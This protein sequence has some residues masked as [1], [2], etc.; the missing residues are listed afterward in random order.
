MCKHSEL[1][2]RTHAQSG[3][4]LSPQQ[5][6]AAQRSPER[7]M[8]RTAGAAR[9]RLAAPPLPPPGPKAEQASIR[10]T[11]GPPLR[12]A[13]RRHSPAKAPGSARPQ[14]PPVLTSPRRA[15]ARHKAAQG[16]GRPAARHSQPRGPPAAGGDKEGPGPGGW[17]GGRLRGGV[18][19]G[20][21]AGPALLPERA[22]CISYA[23]VR[24]HR[25]R[26]HEKLPSIAAVSVKQHTKHGSA[27]EAHG[28]CVKA[29]DKYLAFLNLP[30][31]FGWP[32][33]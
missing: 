21:R 16:K 2:D 18:R 11:R 13:R 9:C 7:E 27:R 23:I 28:A 15:G 22:D 17:G 6:P 26:R 31:S 5:L 8:A 29:A 32:S 20:W 4:V 1:S 24:L 30:A 12:V 10:P 19:A 33:F 14:P 3:P 25:R